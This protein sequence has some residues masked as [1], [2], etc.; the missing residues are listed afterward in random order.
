M[1]RTLLVFWPLKAKTITARKHAFVVIS[2]VCFFCSIV[3]IHYFWS[4]GRKYAT[5]NDQQVLIASCSVNAQG[6]VLSY[7]MSNIR[8]LQDL[9]IRSAIPFCLLLICNVLIIARLARQHK[10]KKEKMRSQDE[11]SNKRKDAQMRSITA[12]L[13]TV[14]FTHL[15]CISPM[16]IMYVVDKSDPFGWTITK[17]WQAVVALRWGL[18]AAVYY[19]NH[20]I[21]CILYIVSSSEFRKDLI[22]LWIKMKKRMKCINSQVFPKSSTTGTSVIEVQPV[23]TA[24]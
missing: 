3:Y 23:S 8:P 18:A 15:I 12:M 22:Q 5:I 21:N 4:Y 6:D 10:T 17:Q 9:F 1:E 11:E 16:Q 14:S 13:L 7:Y 2:L 20:A 19:L 24:P